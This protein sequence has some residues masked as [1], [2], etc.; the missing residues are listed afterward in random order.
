MFTSVITFLNKQ[1]EKVKP[2][3]PTQ[4]DKN[5]QKKEKKKRKSSE[6]VQQEV[7]SKKVKLD[8]G[9]IVESCN[10]TAPS[11]ANSTQK[12]KKNKNKKNKNKKSKENKNN[13]ED[14]D[15]E[16]PTKNKNKKSKNKSN[17]ATDSSNS[18]ENIP[19]KLKAKLGDLPQSTSELTPEDMLSWAEFKLQEPIVRALMELG[20]KQ[21]TKIQQ[22]TLP[23]A[24]H[25]K[26]VFL[27]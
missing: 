19:K 11:L 27:T 25:G 14:N 8:N 18:T 2:E 24:I 1:K 13:T 22:L 6:S 23:A 16:T 3:K 20:F 12:R 9:F 7:P 10:V 5:V 4:K 26:Y 15:S 21:P 17:K